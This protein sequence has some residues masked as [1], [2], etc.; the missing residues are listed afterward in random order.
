MNKEQWKKRC[1]EVI[2]SHSNDI[3]SLGDA[4]YKT[5]ELGY[6]EFQTTKTVKKAFEKLSERVETEI[7][8]T[9]CKI[10]AHTDKEGPTVVVMGELDSVAC[11]Q[12]PDANEL[13]NV[14]AC[15]HNVQLANLYGC[16]IGILKSGVMEALSGKVD[17]VAIPAEECVDYEYRNELVEEGEIAYLGGKQ[18]YLYRGGLDQA[19]MVLQSHVMPLQKDQ[20]CV[21][22]TKANG[23][24]SKIV[25]F[26]GTAAHAGFEPDK[27]VNALNMAELAMNN[28][29]ALRET[30]R[31]EDKVRVSL[32]IKQ[33]GGLVN[34]VPSLVVMEVMVRAFTVEAMTQASEKVNR[35]LKAA[36]YALSGKVEIKETIGYLPLETTSGL[37]QIFRENMVT[38]GGADEAS[39]IH[40]FDTAGSTDLGD[41][42]QVLP[43]MHVW[44]AGVEGGLHTKDY[45]VE[46]PKKAYILPAK[47]LALSV[48]DLLFDQAQEAEKIIKSHKPKYTKEEY[49][50]F[51]KAH[52]K[53]DLFDGTI[54]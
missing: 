10:T 38:Y 1:L 22:N 31:D 30:F 2:D 46:D 36:A 50:A 53:V 34:V 24:I 29:H 19:D 13:G 18:E 37:S 12:H 26:I 23:F 54:I 32:V 51:M 7:A 35:A 45:K 33:G 11:D 40:Q 41:I 6:K 16:A 8:Y 20:S 17:F 4:I 25:K 3:V 49:F 42:S 48:V 15:G 27:G 39:F 52:S 9:G 5:P 21:L 43:C 44:M 47:M 14:H 28:I